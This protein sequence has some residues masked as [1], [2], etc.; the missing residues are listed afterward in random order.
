MSYYPYSLII[1]T[2]E[3]FIAFYSTDVSASYRSVGHRL[4]FTGKD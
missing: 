3:C 4:I 1:K 2:Y